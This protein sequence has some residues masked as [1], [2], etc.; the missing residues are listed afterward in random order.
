M[1]FLHMLMLG[2]HIATAFEPACD[3]L[4]EDFRHDDELGDNYHVVRFPRL[5]PFSARVL[6]CEIA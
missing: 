6:T 3:E 1:L 2:Q 4:G 5:L